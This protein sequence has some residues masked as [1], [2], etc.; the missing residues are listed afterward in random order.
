MRLSRWLVAGGLAW[1][2]AWAWLA[3]A[4]MPNGGWGV[5]ACLTRHTGGFGR[6]LYSRMVAKSGVGILREREVGVIEPRAKGEELSA[7]GSE[8][9]GDVRAQ[10]RGLKQRGFQVVAFA[11]LPFKAEPLQT[12]DQLPEDLMVVFKQARFMG[13]EFAGLVDAWEMVGEPDL[14][15]CTDLPDRVAAYQKAL[16]L[17]LK[18]GA[19]EAEKKPEISNPQVSG[20]RSQVSGL[21]RAPL[22]LM[23]A[24][25]L[26]PGPWLERAARNGLLDYTDAY[27]FHFYGHAEHLTG[28]IEAHRTAAR[29]LS[30]EGYRL[31]GSDT[32]NQQPVTINERQQPL[33]PLWITEAGIEAVAKDD[34]LNPQRRQLQADF[35]IST[36]KQAL[37]ADDVAVFMPFILVHDKDPYAMTL[38]PLHTF[39]AW[40]A[41]AKFTRENPWPQRPLAREPHTVN[42]VV[43]QWL[44]DNRTTTPHKVSGTYR[45]K[46][47]QAIKGELRIYN[48]SDHAVEGKLAVGTL[49]NATASLKPETG[50]LRPE[51]SIVIPSMQMKAIAVEFTPT[52]NGYFRET[53]TAV[54]VEAGSG[55]QVSGLLPHLPENPQVS[56][57]RFQVS[58]AD[59]VR[60]QV[61]FG[62]EAE[63]KL[64]DFTEEPLELKPLPGG[65]IK[66]PQIEPYA[67][68]TNAGVWTTING[69]KA[70]DMD[71]K[72]PQV[73]GLRSQVSAARFW[74]EQPNT[75][76][77]APTMAV[78]AVDG[79]PVGSAGSSELGAR[80]NA[81]NFIRLQLDK[82]MTKDRKVLVVLVDDRGQRYTIWENFGADYYGSRSDIWLN[83][84]DIHA[85][86][87]GPMSTD[88]QFRP[89]RIREVHLRFY[90]NTPNDPVGVRLTLLKAK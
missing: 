39:P 20:L 42:P 75:D 43:M 54:F 55:L 67:T 13:K 49:N 50:D 69:L 86:F 9:H 12:G 46:G 68:G 16:Y 59:S 70:E 25:G 34:F 63:A 30:D 89:E 23:G 6:F 40:D 37:A 7:E 82:P 47:G 28:V 29:Q 88:Y 61:S 76:P 11:Q 19:A 35:T 60:S 77:L 5:D 4:E 22:V 73:S 53:W 80:S 84:E 14:G 72:K 27:N 18:A 85:D 51:D 26:P 57:L 56:G 3:A 52:T 41:Y 65:R 81:Y 87:W 1:A 8:W 58:S 31:S 90:L 17:G 64:A 33:L 79:L 66:F 71:E 32:N 78:A 48:F 15:Y 21:A 44:P 2:A 38:S 24:L 45:F 62:L 83:L 74:I 36:A 10:F